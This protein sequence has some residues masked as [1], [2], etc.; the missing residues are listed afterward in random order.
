MS[1]SMSEQQYPASRETDVK[2]ARVLG[3]KIIHD[4]LGRA[5]YRSPDGRWGNDH[6]PCY[7]TSA[8]DDWGVVGEMVKWFRDEQDEEIEIV[9]GPLGNHAMA[10]EWGLESEWCASP[11]HA[12]AQVLLQV[13]DRDVKDE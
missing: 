5:M 8:P 1:P 3:W 2:V 7:T 12:V 4:N 9:C 6:L 13:A 11:G 10:R